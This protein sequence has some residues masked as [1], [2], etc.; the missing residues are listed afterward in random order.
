MKTL[1][2]KME[3]IEEILEDLKEDI[4]VNLS[5]GVVYDLKS[6]NY[7]IIHETLEYMK[8]VDNED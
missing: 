2:E 6:N 1:E 4:Y 7:K 5:E 3:D 8:E